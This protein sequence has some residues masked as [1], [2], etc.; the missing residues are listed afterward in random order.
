MEAEIERII[1]ECISRGSD[2][3]KRI[4]YEMNVIKRTNTDLFSSYDSSLEED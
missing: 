4:L 2:A 1:N 3:D